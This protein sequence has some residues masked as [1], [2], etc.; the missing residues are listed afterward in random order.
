MICKFVIIHRTKRL[1]K[2]SSARVSTIV[3]AAAHSGRV[4][5]LLTGI[6]VMWSKY[7][8]CLCG[9]ASSH[10]RIK[11]HSFADMPAR[12]SIYTAMP[13]QTCQHTHPYAML[14]ICGHASTL[15]HAHCLDVQSTIRHN[16]HPSFLLSMLVYFA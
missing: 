13:L 5:I 14:C 11:C 6:L 7:I 2:Q 8:L 12:I 10:I 9:H 15:T 4:C 1:W 3:L 16:N